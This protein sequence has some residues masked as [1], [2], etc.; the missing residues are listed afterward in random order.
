MLKPVAP[1]PENVLFKDPKVEVLEGVKAVK[2]IS[3]SDM[4]VLVVNFA[5]NT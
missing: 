1:R 4:R 3:V 2:E 5:D